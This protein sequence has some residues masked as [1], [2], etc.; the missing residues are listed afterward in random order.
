M[1]HVQ[2]VTLSQSVTKPCNRDSSIDTV[3]YSIGYIVTVI[4][5][6]IYET[7]TFRVYDTSNIHFFDLPIAMLWTC[8]L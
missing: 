7:F 8:N 3:C 5:I 6:Y 1:Q 4:F 2:S